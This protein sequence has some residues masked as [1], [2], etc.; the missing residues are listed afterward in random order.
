MLRYNCNKDAI[1]QKIGGK[2]P[3]LGVW[4][5]PMEN[6]KVSGLYFCRN[7]FTGPYILRKIYQTFKC[8]EVLLIRTWF[9]SLREAKILWTINVTHIWNP[10][11]L[12]SIENFPISL[13]I[14][15]DLNVE[16][17]EKIK[18]KVLGIITIGPKWVFF[19]NFLISNI[20]WR[21]YSACKQ[22]LLLL[23]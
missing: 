23:W 10:P 4:Y 12:K 5:A 3:I 17:P 16:A 8:A 2:Q 13:H 22:A 20:F 1:F 6:W 19:K 21:F 14:P 15:I 9:C 11:P 7:F 18:F